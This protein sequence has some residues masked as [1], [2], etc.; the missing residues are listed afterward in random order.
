ME[1][2]WPARDF[3]VRGG[4]PCSWGMASS[5]L[6]HRKSSGAGRVRDVFG[7]VVTGRHGSGVRCA[8]C[9]RARMRGTGPVGAVLHI[10]SG[11]TRSGPAESCGNALKFNTVEILPCA[12]RTSLHMGACPLKIDILEKPRNHA[13]NSESSRGDAPLECATSA[14]DPGRPR[15]SREGPRLKPGPAPL[16]PVGKAHRTRRQGR[17]GAADGPASSLLSAGDPPR[18]PHG[19]GAGG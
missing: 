18:A 11:S 6:S 8:R 15:P 9:R 17:R 13:E 3:R 7:P 14:H 16:F 12:E 10:R 19:T 1:I 5:S 2:R 4:S